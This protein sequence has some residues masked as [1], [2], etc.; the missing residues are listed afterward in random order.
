MN[1][2]DFQKENS[3]IKEISIDNFEEL[4]YFYN[5]RRPQTADSNILDLF[6]WSNCYPTWYYCTDKALIWVAFS[7]EGTHYSAIPCCKD[8]DLKEAFLETKRFFNEVL[9]EKLVMYVVDKEAI[10]VLDLSLD[11]YNITREREFDDYVYDGEKMRTL[12]GRKYHKKKNHYNSFVRN[13]EG[14]YEFKFLDINNE[15]EIKEYLMRWIES[16]EEVDQKEYIDCEIEGKKEILEYQN[17]IDFKIGGIYI[18]GRLEAFTIGKY[19]EAEDMVYIPVEKANPEIRGLYTFINREFLNQAF[20]YAGKVN[21]EDDMG[22][23]GLR[24][25]KESYNPIYMVEKYTIEEK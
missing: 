22:I 9:G 5:L 1:I 7:D 14:R 20:P 11:E 13:Y 4:N 2:K 24:K 16:K 6:L 8:E 18:D 15:E 17:M 21:R 23:E 25:A 12:S 10:D 3:Y 19:Y